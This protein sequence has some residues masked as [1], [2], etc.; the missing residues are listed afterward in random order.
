M[1]LLDESKDI[2]VQEDEKTVGLSFICD[3]KYI[4]SINFS[5]LD[6]LGGL[7]IHFSSRN[8]FYEYYF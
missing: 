1:N 6:S 3:G 2:Y 5:R 4:A 8:M 7:K